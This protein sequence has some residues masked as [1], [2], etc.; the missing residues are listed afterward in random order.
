MEQGIKKHAVINEGIEYLNLSELCV[1]FEL[2]PQ[3]VQSLIDNRGISRKVAISISVKHNG[4]VPR[5]RMG[6]EVVVNGSTFPSR[7]S[8]CRANDVIL[9][10]V[11][12]LEKKGFSFEEAVQ[13][14][15]LRRKVK[16]K[17]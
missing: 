17:K 2:D 15:R 12:R 8:A 5:N 1:K 9:S 13:K 4:N 11:S 10:T 6:E 16:E 14:E 3:K 7:S